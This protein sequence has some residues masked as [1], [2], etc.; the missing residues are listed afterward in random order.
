VDGGAPSAGGVR[1]A[2]VAL[3]TVIGGAWGRVV[4]IIRIVP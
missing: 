2:N 4:V 3:G 1:G